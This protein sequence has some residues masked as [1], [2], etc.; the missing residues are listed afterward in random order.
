[1]KR[2][3]LAVVGFDKCMREWRAYAVATHAHLGGFGD[4]LP[5]SAGVDGIA[6]RKTLGAVQFT[7]GEHAQAD[8]HDGIGLAFDHDQPEAVTRGN[9]VQWV[10]QILAVLIVAVVLHQE[11]AHFTVVGALRADGVYRLIS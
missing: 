3:A 10:W 7:R 9:G 8:V 4:G 5:C 6:V 2:L 1:M 11:G